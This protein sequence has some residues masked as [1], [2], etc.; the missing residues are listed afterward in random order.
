M[1]PT[2][3]ADGGK[4]R[5]PKPDIRQRVKDL[6]TLINGTS[7]LD[8]SPQSSEISVEEETERV[9]ELERMEDQGNKA[10]QINRI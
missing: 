5:D 10:F 8:T 4:H 9:Y 1:M 2:I 7:P 6:G 3:V